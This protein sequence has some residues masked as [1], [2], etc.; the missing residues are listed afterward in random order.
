MPV[1]RFPDS[2]ADTAFTILTLD[3]NSV[4]HF[5]PKKCI[6]LREHPVLL[7]LTKAESFYFTFNINWYSSFLSLFFY[8]NKFAIGKTGGNKKLDDARLRLYAEA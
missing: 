7:T 8:N 5:T 2:Y 4:Y 6:D 1:R 3:N